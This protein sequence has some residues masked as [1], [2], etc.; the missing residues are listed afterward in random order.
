LPGYRFI[1]L[2]FPAANQTTGQVIADSPHLSLIQAT[3]R[4][5]RQGIKNV[6]FV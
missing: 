4:I 1:S 3:Q 6:G 5:S 2:Q